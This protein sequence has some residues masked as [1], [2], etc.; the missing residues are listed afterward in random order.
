MSAVTPR[1]REIIGWM[2]AGKTAAE[3]GAILAISPITV[4]THIA[5]AKAKLGVFK[6]TALVAEA[7]RNGIIR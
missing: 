5:N 4:T 3:I 2:A 1:E 7:L 6:E